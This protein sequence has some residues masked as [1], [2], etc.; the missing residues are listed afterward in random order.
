MTELATSR[1]GS[2][3]IL[4]TQVAQAVAIIGDRW[5]FL[6]I[7]DVYLGVRKFEELR[8]RSGV[9]RGTLTSRLKSL[10]KKG[11]LY[12]SPYQDS[13]VRYDYRL[14]EK[15]LDLYPMVLMI[16]AWDHHWGP[17]IDLPQMLVH[18][19]CGS[20]TVPVYRCRE[21]HQ[22]AL[23][24]DVSFSPGEHFDDAKKLPPRYQRRSK[25]IEEKS[26]DLEVHQVRA[27]DCI[28]DRW[29]SLVLAAGFFGLRRFDDI[30][31]AIGIATNILSDRLRMLV[32]AEVLIRQKYQEQPARYEYHLS[33]KGKGLYPYILA[34][35]DWANR[36]LISPGKE[37]LY[38]TH[39]PCNSPFHG[40]A[41]CSAC[42][43][44]LLPWDVEFRSN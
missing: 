44:I 15:G 34:L 39:V 38:L 28:G 40:E 3:L 18:K 25:T 6:I 19:V 20:E 24:S 1:V 42:A 33:E 9:A 11:I 32:Q 29:T 5:S 43:E 21:C 16:W 8:S 13:P 12:K 30:T 36:W 4:N 37:P 31:I 22:P 26:G 27:L 14:T 2:D 10:V 35:H 23:P 7:R 17:R 41:I